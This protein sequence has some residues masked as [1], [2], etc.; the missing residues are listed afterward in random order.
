M[1][2]YVLILCPHANGRAGLSEA[3]MG[4]FPVL[5]ARDPAQALR[6]V[7]QRPSCR[8]AYCAMGGDA[9]TELATAAAL[10]KACPGVRIIALVQQ[11]C[12]D[13]LRLAAESGLLDDICQ[14]PISP[15]LLRRQTRATF[16]PVVRQPSDTACACRLTREEIEFLLGRPAPDKRGGYRLTEH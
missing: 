14:L 11:P 6:L 15:E 16:T 4:F 9:A 12:S 13:A 3:L 5:A 1:P 8:L 10:K 7:K 2:P